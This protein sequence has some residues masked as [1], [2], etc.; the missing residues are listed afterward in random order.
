M[1]GKGWY[2][3]AGEYPAGWEKKVKVVNL[4]TPKKKGLVSQTTKPKYAKREDDSSKTYSDIVP[5]KGGIPPIGNIVLKS[6]PPPFAHIRSNRCSTASKPKPSVVRPAVDIGL[7]AY[8]PLSQP[9]LQIPFFGLP[10]SIFTFFPS[11]TILMGLLLHSLGLPRLV[12]FLSSH[13]LF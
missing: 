3:Y 8:W 1:V 2:L 6:S 9:H 10:W 7:W 5:Y 4:P 12:C 13:L 11:L